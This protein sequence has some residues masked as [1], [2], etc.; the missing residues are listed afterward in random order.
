MTSESAQT[1]RLLEACG[2]G[3]PR[4][5]SNGKSEARREH[6]DPAENDGRCWNEKMITALPGI[7]LHRNTLSSVYSFAL[8]FCRWPG[9]C[10]S[11]LPK[12]GGPI[13]SNC[14]IPQDRTDSYV[15]STIPP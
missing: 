11:P 15:K 7:H 3:T 12:E 9:G 14:R 13:T 4:N 6:P 10:S 8:A 1:R 5:R 2:A